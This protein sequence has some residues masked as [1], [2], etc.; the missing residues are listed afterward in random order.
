MAIKTPA[1]L[2]LIRES[3]RWANLAHMLLQR[4][5][6]VGATETEVS[7]RSSNEATLAMVQAIGPIYSA[8][9]WQ[10]E[11]VGGGYRG[12]IGCGGAIPHAL[13][14]NTTFRSGDVLLTGE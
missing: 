3:I 13:S 2:G 5:T 11:Q 9:S 1:E 8:Q 12:Q 10:A 6:V 14:N 4:Y 7:M